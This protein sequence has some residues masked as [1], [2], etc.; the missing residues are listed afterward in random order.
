[1]KKSIFLISLISLMMLTSVIG[2][3]YQ[4]VWVAE[5]PTGFFS[6]LTGTTL[7]ITGGCNGDTYWSKTKNA[8]L[9][10]YNCNSDCT[11]C[12]TK[13]VSDSMCDAQ[14]T[15]TTTSTTSTSTTSVSGSDYDCRFPDAKCVGDRPVQCAYE[16]TINGIDYGTWVAQPYDCPS[17][18]ECVAE[19]SFSSAT[20]ELVQ[21][22][23]DTNCNF[24]SNRCSGYTE[25]TCAFERTI[26]GIDR[27]NWIDILECSDGWKCRNGEKIS[28]S[29]G[30]PTTTSNSQDVSSLDYECVFPDARCLNDVPVQCA[31]EETIGGIDYGNWV[32]Q[33]YACTGEYECVADPDFATAR[34]DLK[35]T[36]PVLAQT[37]EE[38]NCDFPSE[39][40][41]EGLEQTCAYENT[42]NGVDRGNWVDM[43]E[44]SAGW[45]CGADGSEVRIFS[46][47]DEDGINDLIDNCVNVKNSNQLDSDG[48][49]VGDICDMPEVN[50]VDRDGVLNSL[51]NCPTIRNENQLDSDGDGLGDVCDLCP[52]DVENRCESAVGSGQSSLPIVPLVVLVLGL[53]GLLVWKNPLFLV[54]I[55]GG[56]IWVVLGLFGV[57]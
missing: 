52:A 28:C 41:F 17:D 44:G 9:E 15:S 14:P 56:L 49:G 12:Y 8:C 36:K 27:G 2:Q 46:D 3:E 47:W 51:D 18:Y 45:V 48:D 4:D 54:P 23:D 50:D 7:A 1:M 5:E 22:S 31:F 19:P 35:D 34:C 21:I 39:R 10:K 55:V 57:I 40:C 20:C 16:D 25:Q 53:V 24:P 30:F 26:N 11:L 33:P 6:F 32:S 43:L 42:F 38:T 13:T 37:I 29:S